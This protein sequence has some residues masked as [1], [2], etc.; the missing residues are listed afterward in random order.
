MGWRRRRR[1]TVKTVPDRSAVSSVIHIPAAICYHFHSTPAR[2]TRWLTIPTRNTCI[3]SS[4]KAVVTDKFG[5]QNK[6]APPMAWI[7]HRSRLIIGLSRFSQGVEVY[8]FIIQSYWWATI[9]RSVDY[10]AYMPGCL[11]LAPWR[12][13][14]SILHDT[15]PNLWMQIRI[16]FCNKRIHITTQENKPHKFC[17]QSQYLASTNV[18]KIGTVRVNL[19]VKAVD[20]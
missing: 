13:S 17:Q 4:P 10:S 14:F 19:F 15:R 18:R 6:L 11:R 5:R 1:P 7:V 16:N 3:F 9:G 8:V 20:P 12:A 2:H